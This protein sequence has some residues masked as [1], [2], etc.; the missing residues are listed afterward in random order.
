MV[1]HTSEQP[2]A[3]CQRIGKTIGGQT[4]ME[5]ALLLAVLMNGISYCFSDNI[6]LKMYQAR[7]V[8]AHE[9]PALHGMVSIMTA[10][11]RLKSSARP[12]LEASDA[13]R[14]NV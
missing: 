4:G 13:T 14:A 5:I 2:R 7:P 3:Y 10:S 11:K 8:D 1:A 12:A 9:E 6:V